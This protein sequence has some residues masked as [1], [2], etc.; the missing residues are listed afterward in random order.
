MGSMGEWDIA[1]LISGG[2]TLYNNIVQEGPVIM[3][4]GPP[5][6]QVHMCTTDIIMLKDVCIQY[7]IDGTRQG[8]I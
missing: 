4:P 2:L 7:T 6:K 1:C 5:G 8:M 3:P